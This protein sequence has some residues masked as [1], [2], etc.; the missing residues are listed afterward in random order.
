MTYLSMADAAY[1]QN[2]PPGFPI[3]AGYYGGAAAYNVWTRGDW[4][5]F[6]GFRLPIYVPAD[7]GNGQQDGADA[8]GKLV[9]LGVPRGCRTVVDME[10]RRDAEYLSNFG[11]VLQAHEYRV[12]VYGSLSTVFGNP[13]LDGYWVADY[14]VTMEQVRQVM[15]MAHVRGIQDRN[16]AT[17]GYDASLVKA[18]TEGEMWHG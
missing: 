9:Q 17:P 7:P 1:P 13:P 16:N 11:A 8:V 12:E 6:P 15:A 4:L 2:I 10:T 3:V 5:A 18:W 14:G